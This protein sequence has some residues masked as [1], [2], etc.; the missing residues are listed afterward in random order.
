MN[1]QQTEL[2]DSSPM[3]F[4][5]YRGKPMIDVPAHY[6]LYLFND[7]CNHPDVKKYILD[8]L[9]ALKKEAGHVKR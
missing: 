4:G 7:G 3:P 2:T 6:L 8:N 1:S 9:E 5:K